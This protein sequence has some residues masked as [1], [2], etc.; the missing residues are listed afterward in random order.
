M[1]LDEA[2]ELALAQPRGLDDDE[3]R[4]G[5]VERGGR[6]VRQPVARLAHQHRAP[7][8]AEQRAGGGLA[9]EKGQVLRRLARGELGAAHGVTARGRA[10]Q[11][12]RAL[13][14]QARIVTGEQHQAAGGGRVVEEAREPARVELRQGQTRAAGRARNAAI[15]PS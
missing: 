3:A 2:G 5:A 7:A 9:G 1:A 14:N 13:P 12:L 11:R 15:T 6:G 10:Q 8:A 4:A